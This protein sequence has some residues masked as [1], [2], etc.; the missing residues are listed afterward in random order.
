MKIAMIGYGN[1]GTA[2]VR[3]LSEIDKQ[4]KQYVFTS[5]ITRKMGIVDL[6]GSPAMLVDKRLKDAIGSS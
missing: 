1:V 3:L 6:G 5:I 2:L 4:G